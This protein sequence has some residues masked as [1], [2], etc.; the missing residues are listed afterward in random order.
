M[1]GSGVVPRLARAPAG[2]TPA[3]HLKSGNIRFREAYPVQPVGTVSL[4]KRVER[5]VAE[6]SVV[7]CPG[8]S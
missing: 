3:S 2:A 7:H 1:S 8:E 4:A 5:T 6:N